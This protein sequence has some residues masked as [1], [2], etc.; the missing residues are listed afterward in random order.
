MRRSRWTQGESSRSSSAT[1]SAGRPAAALWAAR[2][3][4]GQLQVAVDGVADQVDRGEAGMGHGRSLASAG[5]ARRY[6]CAHGQPGRP[7]APG[8]GA[9]RRA[10]RP[11]H[12]RRPW[13]RQ[14]RRCWPCD[15]WPSACSRRT[16]ARRR[17]RALCERSRREARQLGLPLVTLEEH[18]SLDLTIDGADEV[19]PQLRLIK[20]GGGALLREKI[21]A[22][23]SRRE[24]IVVDA[25]K[26][27]DAPG[28][29]PCPAGRGDALRLADPAAVPGGARRPGRPAPRGGRAGRS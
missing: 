5:G 15:A 16:P 29:P 20:G 26:L 1:V 7:E 17:R 4:L 19:D 27:S 21:V 9:R 8:G 11:G 14:H 28:H 22:Q 12:G 10:G 2:E 6:P 23:A 18:P 3:A 24:V 13:R 25:S